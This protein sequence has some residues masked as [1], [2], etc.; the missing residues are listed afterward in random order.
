MKRTRRLADIDEGTQ[1]GIVFF[2][3]SCG[4]R[5]EVDSRMAGKKGH[6]KKC[7]QLM[8]IPRAENLASMTGIAAVAPAGAT[9][10]AE[11]GGPVNWLRT[12]SSDVGLAPL[13][14]DRMPG[15]PRKPKPAPTPLD[16]LGDSK[17]Y[18][19]A[20]P[21]RGEPIRRS[22]GRPNYLVMFWRGE[23]GS[24]QKLFRHI[25]EFAYLISVPFLILLLLGAAIRNRPLALFAA[26]V[27]VV[28]NLG[29]IASG[30]ANLAVV[31]LRD[32]LQFHKMK[33][34]LRRVIEP[35]LTIGL[36]I[37]AFTFIPWL[38]TGQA[39]R[40]NAVSRLRSGAKA[41]GREMEGELK[42]TVEEVEGL[43][44]K[45]LETQ[46]RQTLKT[47][48]TGEGGEPSSTRGPST[49]PDVDNV[50]RDVRQRARKAVDESLKRP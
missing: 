37:V 7:G 3:M 50:L 46:T 35:V 24:V 27:V 4:A 22:S 21:A 42:K 47:I 34:P 1:M 26:T 6:C 20:E 13:T 43:D 49:G 12:A 10:G 30:I 41:L 17:P 31:P 11:P 39:S 19:L 29:R 45:K 14:V 16:D 48:G 15:V 28:L 44:V 2:C 38:A 5:F 32:G 33:K 18:S 9:V 23:L 40:G 36:V 25:N 8:Q